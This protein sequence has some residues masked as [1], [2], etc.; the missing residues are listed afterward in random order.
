[1][2]TLCLANGRDD[3]FIHQ[4]ADSQSCCYHCRSRRGEN[5]GIDTMHR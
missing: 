3:G 1:M 2:S 4:G 5:D